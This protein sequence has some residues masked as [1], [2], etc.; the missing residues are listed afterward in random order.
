MNYK[1]SYDGVINALKTIIG[2]AN[3]QGHIIVRIEDIENAIPELKENED[4][5]IRKAIISIVAFSP[6]A[7]FDKVSVSREDVLAWL[8]KQKSVEQNNTTD[9]Q[10][11]SAL[12]AWK[13]MRLEVYAQARGNRHE[14][15]V[16][17]DSTKMFSLNDIDEII[18]NIEDEIKKP[19]Y[20]TFNI[21][22]K[23]KVGDWIINNQG[24]AFQIAYIDE[25]NSRYVFEIGG[26]TKEE[27][28]YESIAFA[29]NH[30][31][32]WTID[33]AK[34]GDVLV[35]KDNQ[36]FIYN[37]KYDTFW[38][39]AYCGMNCT[40]NSFLLAQEKC[41]WTGR[42]GVKPSSKEQRKQL[43][44]NMRAEGCLWNE[45]EKRIITSIQELPKMDDFNDLNDWLKCIQKYNEKFG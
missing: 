16:S 40:G 31:R 5:K 7:M 33:D 21:I 24:S 12:E 32:K 28:N 17:D 34:D 44:Q 35:S 37:G 10:H 9:S 41:H 39:G 13:E 23:F 8:E 15:N 26:Y 45:K 6:T 22:P 25:E 3:K 27:M 19:K 29:N 20:S 30:Y 36:P 2:N 43:F 38:V 18:E 11:K 14:L 4:E 1:D 42:E